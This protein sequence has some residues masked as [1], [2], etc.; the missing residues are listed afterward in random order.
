MARPVL[1]SVAALLGLLASGASAA[2]QV[3]HDGQLWINATLFGT[4]DRL[5]YFA[6]IQPRFGDGISRLDQLILRPAV[7]WRID[8][9]FTVYQGYAYVETAPLGQPLIAEDRSFQQ[10]DW[11]I[12]EVGGARIS[13]RTRFEQRWQ[14]N[15][16]D[17][18]FRI[19]EQVR[20]AYPATA[21]KAGVAL[22][23]WTE[24]FFALN[25]TDWGARAGFDR[26]RSFV[27]FEIPVAGKSTLEIGYINQT[28]NAPRAR[29]EMDHILSLNLLVR[30]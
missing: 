30:Q 22:L 4:V 3:A 6:E 19:R 14:S 17:V 13:S 15:G 7:G 21:D 16:R 18:G 8:D 2:A 26:V 24:A 23:G 29:T 28:V 10:L 12:G 11:V 25:D 20:A 9:R 5:A 1:S 27:G